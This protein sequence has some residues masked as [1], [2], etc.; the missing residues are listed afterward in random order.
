MSAAKQRL[1]DKAAEQKV[2][3]RANQDRVGE[4]LAAQLDRVQQGKDS[5]QLSEEL[6]VAF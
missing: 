4:S 6:K 2:W 1:L 3:K 5:V